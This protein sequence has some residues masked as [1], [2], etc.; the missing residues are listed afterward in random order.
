MKLSNLSCMFPT[1]LLIWSMSFLTF[2]KV[3][4]TYSSERSPGFSFFYFNRNS[5]N[6][7]MKQPTLENQ[8]TFINLFLIYLGVLVSLFITNSFF[9]GGGSG[10]RGGG[11]FA[12]FSS[13]IKMITVHAAICTL[14]RYDCW[15]V[16]KFW[17]ISHT[18]L[19]FKRLLLIEKWPKKWHLELTLILCFMLPHH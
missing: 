14:L 10:G 16:R 13:T 4:N 7:F 1:S 17:N 15:R 5:R 2:S 3:K 12:T 11:S 9:L 19:D 8:K 18:A 6:S